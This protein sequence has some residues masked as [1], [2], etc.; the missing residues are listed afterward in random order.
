MS[1]I[2]TTANA[3]A[4]ALYLFAEYPD[5]AEKLIAEVD[6]VLKGELAT[7]QALSRLEYLDIFVKESMR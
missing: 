3:S 6:E 1:C 7:F 5:A 2:E 4:F